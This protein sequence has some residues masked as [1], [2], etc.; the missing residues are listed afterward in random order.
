MATWLTT[1]YTPIANL[2]APD[3]IIEFAKNI[4]NNGESSIDIE[5]VKSIYLDYLQNLIKTSKKTLPDYFKA[6]KNSLSELNFE[7]DINSFSEHEGVGVEW[8][9]SSNVR[10]SIKNN[11]ITASYTPQVSEDN[12]ENFETR[13]YL[14]IAHSILFISARISKYSFMR[15]HIVSS[16]RTGALMF[17]VE[18]DRSTI[19]I[20][21]VM[22]SIGSL[23]IDPNDKKRLI[24][25]LYEKTV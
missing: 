3:E 14:V 19:L 22:R 12:N 13:L 24:G 5:K 7:L 17:Q 18:M 21:E 10:Y 11:K 16:E 15:P 23:D 1:I 9:S 8:T 20:D 4:L 2:D 25:D 6:D